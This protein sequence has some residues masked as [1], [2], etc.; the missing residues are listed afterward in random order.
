MRLGS[1]WSNGRFPAWRYHPALMPLVC[2]TVWS[3]GPD[4]ASVPTSHHSG[5]YTHGQRNVDS[6]PHPPARAHRAGKPPPPPTPSGRGGTGGAPA[7]CRTIRRVPATGDCRFSLL[8]PFPRSHPGEGP[9]RS[10]T[11]YPYRGTEIRMQ[12]WMRGIMP[13]PTLSR[14]AVV[15]LEGLVWSSMAKVPL[16]VRTQ[17]CGCKW[18]GETIQCQRTARPRA[19]AH[20]LSIPSKRRVSAGHRLGRP[21]PQRDQRGA[22]RYRTMP[23]ST[24]SGFHAKAGL[25]LAPGHRRRGDRSVRTVNPFCF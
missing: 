15:R 24:W 8:E 11:I 25:G 3:P 2:A 1:R 13:D 7:N 23:A 4:F 14:C 5:Y 20:G 18:P 22:D 9:F 6:V 19:A 12:H 17:R 21:S 16:P 10:Q